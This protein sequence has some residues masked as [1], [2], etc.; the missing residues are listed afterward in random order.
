MQIR[1]WNRDVLRARKDHPAWL[2]PTYDQPI[3]DD[4]VDEVEEEQHAE[5]IGEPAPEGR[6]VQGRGSPKQCRSTGSPDEQAEKSCYL[7]LLRRSGRGDRLDLLGEM[8]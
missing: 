2:D 3:Q 5:G 7:T 8:A 1:V 4:Q 6:I